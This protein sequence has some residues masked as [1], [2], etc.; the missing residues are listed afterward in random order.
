MREI[1]AGLQVSVDRFI[2]G[3]GRAIDWIEAW[4]DPFE[5]MP[6]ARKL[7]IAAWATVMRFRLCWGARAPIAR[8]LRWHGRPRRDLR[9]ANDDC[10]ND[11]GHG[12]AANSPD[13][14]K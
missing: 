5:A 1:I 10:S 8:L 14:G 2:E 3:P 6:E 12:R 4:K 7:S 11:N 13:R 9:R